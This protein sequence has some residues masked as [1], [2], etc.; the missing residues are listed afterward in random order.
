MKTLKSD[1]ILAPA[2]LG[3]KW[4]FINRK[5]DFEIPLQF[6][7]AHGFYEGRA[8]VV[9]GQKFGFID[10]T[11]A[12]VIPPIYDLDKSFNFFVNGFTKVRLEDRS[13][14]ISTN[15]RKLDINKYEEIYEFSEGLAAVKLKIGGYTQIYGYLRICRRDGC[16]SV[17]R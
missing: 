6:D 3:K 5:G 9:L 11:G 17:K 16:S 13:F 15:G 14:M 10:D 7:Y 12:F 1:K 2:S 4:G 8:K